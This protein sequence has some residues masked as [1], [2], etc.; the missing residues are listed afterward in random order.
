[1]A[2]KIAMTAMGPM[3]TAF[4]RYLIATACL[5]PFAWRGVRD[6]MKTREGVFEFL[7]LGL[8]G[9]FA[10][11][12]F[13]FKGLQYESAGTTA[14]VITTNPALTALLSALI[15]KERLSPLRLMGFSL[16]F[17]GALL[18]LGNGDLEKIL[19]LDFGHGALLLGLAVAVWSV[20][21]LLSKK[22]VKRVS[23]VTAT[24]ASFAF[25][26]PMLFVAALLEAPLASALAAPPKAWVAVAFMGIF[27]SS[28]AFALFLKGVEKIGATRASVFIYLVPAFAIFFA[29]FI[30]G[31]TITPEKLMGG[32]VIVAGV[33]LTTGK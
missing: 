14:L 20:Y 6:G 32:G 25:G 28:V 1:M 31:E 19:A 2:G 12:W 8:T 29:Y 21:V 5:L 16:A 3:S 33:W 4:W 13:F 11:H 26:L 30:L 9:I 27:C 23:A 24:A 15:Y 10:Y 22:A 18:V 7:L 17:F